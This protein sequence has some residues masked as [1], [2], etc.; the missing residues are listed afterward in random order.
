M[1]GLRTEDRAAYRCSDR[2]TSTVVL[3]EGVAS[4]IEVIPK[5]SAMDS[6]LGEDFP[7]LANGD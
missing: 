2:M 4:V 6:D 7:G 1:S 3:N 5:D